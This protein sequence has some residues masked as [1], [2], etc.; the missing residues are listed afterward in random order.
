MLHSA[1]SVRLT[2]SVGPPLWSYELMRATAALHPRVCAGHVTPRTHPP[3]PALFIVW[4]SLVKSRSPLGA[5]C[6]ERWLSHRPSH[7]SGFCLVTFFHS[8]S[9]GRLNPLHQIFP[10]SLN[11]GQSRVNTPGLLSLSH[12]RGG[13]IT[14]GAFCLFVPRLKKLN[15]AACRGGPQW[16]E[17]QRRGMGVGGWVVLVRSRGGGGTWWE[18][19]RKV[20]CWSLRRSV[21]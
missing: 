7:W 1:C 19:V 2:W 8:I 4:E 21:R 18:H 14:P 11:N 15:W 20:R 6:P 9:G 16:E 12:P 5:Q 3:R 17:G 10:F 13:L